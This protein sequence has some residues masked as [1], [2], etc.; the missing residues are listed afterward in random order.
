MRPIARSR[1]LAA[2]AAGVCIAA[3]CGNL[4]AFASRQRLLAAPDVIEWRFD[5]LESIGGHATHVVGAPRLVDS[6]A[7]RAVAFD[8]VD[9]GLIV[10]G[11]PLQGLARF[12]IEVLLQPD[13]GGLE[14]QRFLHVEG[15]G[16][17]SVTGNGKRALMELRLAPAGWALDSYLRHDAIGLTLLDRARTHSTGAWHAA[18]LVYDGRTMTHYVDGTRE[19]SGE[20]AFPPLGPGRT[21]IGVRQNLVSFFKGRIA[22]VRVTGE[23]LPAAALLRP[24]WRP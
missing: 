17:Q 4:S 12:T 1:S 7:G 8:G 21:S 19:L 11:N 13:A 2:C 10:E 5:S 20:V 15:A 9:D 23:A 14:E 18:A 16:G 24:G 22:M 6:P 3:A